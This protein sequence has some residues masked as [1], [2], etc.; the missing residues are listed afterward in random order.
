[1][2]TDKYIKLSVI[3][4]IRSWDFDNNGDLSGRQ[5]FIKVND[6]S[7]YNYLMEKTDKWKSVVKA[8]RKYLIG[9]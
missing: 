3:R 5:F 9:Q 1:M 6:D 7:E 4:F 2:V 8:S